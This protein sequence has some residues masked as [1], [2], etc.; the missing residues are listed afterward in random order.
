MPVNEASEILALALIFVVHLV[1]GLMLVWGMLDGDAPARWWRRGDDPG[2][3]PPGPRP[4]SPPATRSPLPLPACAASS[5]RL[6]DERN[7]R[8]A[9]PRAPRR[10]ER[11]PLP[12]RSP[13]RRQ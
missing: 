10:P 5:V 1:G 9:H 13:S 6:R 3:D 4:T 11:A 7:L 8:D 2:D 12:G